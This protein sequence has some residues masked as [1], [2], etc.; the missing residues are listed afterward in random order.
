MKKLIVILLVCNISITFA[1]EYRGPYL[2]T[3][4]SLDMVTDASSLALGEALVANKFS[5]YAF[6]SNPATL[7]NQK[8]VNI[9]YNYRSLNW[10]NYFGN[11][12]YFSA[13]A[14]SSTSIGNFGITLNQLYFEKE[15]TSYERVFI[16]TYS[17]ALVDNLMIGAN[18]KLFNR[19]F[20]LPAP[21]QL[22]TTPALIFDLGLIY[23][24]G[25]IIS[26]EK[27]SDDLNLGLSI[28]NFGT[29]YREKVQGIEDYLLLPRYLRFGFSY[30]ANFLYDQANESRLDLLVTTEYSNMLNAPNYMQDSRDNWGVG[31]EA[32]FFKVFSLRY[33]GIIS[34]VTNIFSERGKFISRYGFGFQ[35]PLEKLGL[36]IPITIKF[37]YTPLQV[38]KAALRGFQ[39]NNTLN[40]F[41]LLFSYNKDLF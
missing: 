41:T 6:F 36:E 27:F 16:L 30:K 25:K 21:A 34:Q 20:S 3:T 31:F 24:V 1:Q 17:R 8:G 26:D 38:Q 15:K 29:D 33:G 14:Q 11:A 23:N 2:I 13:G 22:E 5:S 37:D 39:S 12:F 35:L 10:S 9:F 32:L 19:N 18:A 28:Q 4:S 40:N 7:Q